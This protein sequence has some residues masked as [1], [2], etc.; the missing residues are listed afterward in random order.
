MLHVRFR[1]IL[2]WLSFSR[3]QS[4]ILISLPSTER[5][6]YNF[7]ARLPLVI[8]LWRKY[9]KRAISRDFETATFFARTIRHANFPALLGVLLLEFLRK[10]ASNNHYLA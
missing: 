8:I 10:T 2:R 1:A 6:F 9:A 3:E 5:S 7:R 4:R